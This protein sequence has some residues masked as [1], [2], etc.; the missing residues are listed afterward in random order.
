[1]RIEAIQ[2]VCASFPLCDYMCNAFHGDDP[3]GFQALVFSLDLFGMAQLCLTWL[4]VALYHRKESGTV[5]IC[6]VFC[7]RL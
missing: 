5:V 3:L 1:M 2:H 7:I 6:A 4:L